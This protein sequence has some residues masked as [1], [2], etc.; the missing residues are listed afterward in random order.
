MKLRVTVHGVSYEVD[1]EILDDDGLMAT[2]T[3]IQRIA[4]PMSQQSTPQ[5]QVPQPQQTISN[6]DGVTAPIA[7]T[8]KEIKI[9]IGDSIKKDQIVMIIEA[10]KMNT[11]ISSPQDGKV[12]DIKVSVGDSVRDGQILVE[13]E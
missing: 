6:G 5:K 11:E 13:F 1:V 12:K 10:M 2:P 8:V 4:T 3:P 7:G 9:K